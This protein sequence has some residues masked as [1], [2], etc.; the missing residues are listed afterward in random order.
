MT[1]GTPG[2]FRDPSDPSVARWHDGDK[3]TEHTL[4]I[5]DQTPGIEPAPP[6]PS[7]SSEAAAGAT[8]AAAA[9]SFAPSDPDFR[10]PRHGGSGR[11]SGLPAWAKIGA[12]V[13]VVL[14]VILAFVVTSSGNNNNN[15]KTATVD[16]SAPD[17]KAAVA[18]ARSAGLADNVSDAR[19]GA[20]IQRICA[21]A[22]NPSLIDQL[23]Q[24]LGQL[25]AT[26]T[27]EVRSNVAALGEGA[28]TRC[29]SDMAK[30]PDLIGRLQDQAAVAFTTT[31]TSPTVLGGTDTGTSLG[32]TAGTDG[33]T[34]TTVKGSKTSTTVKGGKTTTTKATTTT[35]TIPL[36]RALP[37]QACS[38]EGAKG[39]N[40]ITGAGMT[41]RKACFGT[42]L[43]WSES[44]CSTTPTAPPT[45]ATTPT[46]APTTTTTGSG[47]TGGL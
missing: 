20:L 7:T 35:T 17:L 2:W 21:A 34:G 41:C 14:L 23:A 24:D 8:G 12:P 25:P 11:L 45:S 28:T 27:A 42:K 38:P 13:A 47:T 6:T 10:I 29:R 30:A 3:W 26:D 5:A 46:S 37:N 39:V 1:D 36:P 15:D 19:A 32:G 40:K 43:V 22:K 4:V 33:G 9:G 44:T 31:T 16:T 18:A